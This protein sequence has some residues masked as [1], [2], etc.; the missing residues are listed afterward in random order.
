MNQN[1]F[2]ALERI[3]TLIDEETKDD[4]YETNQGRKFYT[5]YRDGNE[6]PGGKIKFAVYTGMVKT[7]FRPSDSPNE[8]PYNI[9]GNAMLA[10]YLQLVASNILN[11]V[12]SSSV[13]HSWSLRLSQKMSQHA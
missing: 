13:Y 1:Y 7:G 9:P 10:T 6:L 2:K 5:F 4:D 3:V 8:L 11:Q 12:D